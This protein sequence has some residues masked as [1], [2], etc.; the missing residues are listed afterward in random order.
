MKEF[1]FELRP[2]TKTKYYYQEVP[3]PTGKSVTIDESDIFYDEN[4]NEIGTGLCY[5]THNGKL[6]EDDG[7]PRYYHENTVVGGFDSNIADELIY[8][9]VSKDGKNTSRLYRPEI[10]RL[11]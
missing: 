6:I 10:K 9:G 4:D 8:E 5:V 2:K 3:K 1:Y 7:I 11:A